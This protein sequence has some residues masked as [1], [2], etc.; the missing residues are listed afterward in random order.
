MDECSPGPFNRDPFLAVPEEGDP[1]AAA[2]NNK[3]V[4]EAPSKV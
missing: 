2:V 4:G 3:D 1:P